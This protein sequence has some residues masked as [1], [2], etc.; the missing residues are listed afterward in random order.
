LAPKTIRDLEREGRALLCGLPGGG[1]ETKVLLLRATGLSETRLLSSPER[2]VPPR[3]EELFFRFVRERLAGRPLAYVTGRQEFWSLSLRVSP[4]VLIPRPETEMLVERVLALSKRGRETILDMGTGCGNIAIALARELPAAA[5]CAAD[6]SLR[7]LRLA[8]R[9][10]E[11]QG[12]GRVEFV[13]SNLFSAFRGSGR[14]FDF[15]VSN[16]P[17]IAHGEWDGLP[18]EVRDHE[19]RRALLAGETGLEFIGRLVRG[20]RRFLRPGGYLIF[21]MGETQHRPVL[22]LF[23]RGWME[24]ETGWDLAGKPRFITARTTD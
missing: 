12:A 1:L 16:P 21:E 9:N 4:A 23:G 6:V 20:A 10:A 2:P 17:Y 22:A 14:R 5:L 18:A 11:S 24:V 13:R 8:R 15:I 19:P 7:A 3:R